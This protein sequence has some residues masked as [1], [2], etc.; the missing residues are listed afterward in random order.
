MIISFA[1]NNIGYDGKKIMSD[2]WGIRDGNLK[3]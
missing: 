3:L 2:A 1:G